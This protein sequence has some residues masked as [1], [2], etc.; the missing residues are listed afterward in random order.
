M[1]ASLM[2]SELQLAASCKKEMAVSCVMLFLMYSSHADFRASTSHL[3][4]VAIKCPEYFSR[5]S[6]LTS[7]VYKKCRNDLRISTCM[8]VCK[9]L[10][11]P[12]AK[13]ALN[14]EDLDTYIVAF[15]NMLEFVTNQF[16][17]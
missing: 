7:A 8:S 2:A 1:A 6:S 3:W 5:S 17:T 9:F 13:K 14:T 10:V 16:V 11:S 4:A 12:F 15:I